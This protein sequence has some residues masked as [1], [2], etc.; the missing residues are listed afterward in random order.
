VIV[1]IPPCIP[2]RLLSNIFASPEESR[3]TV[4]LFP[5][6]WRTVALKKIGALVPDGPARALFH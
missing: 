4:I 6:G 5:D 1:A 3:A 2:C